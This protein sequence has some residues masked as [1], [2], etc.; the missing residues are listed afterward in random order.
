[1]CVSSNHGVLT[2]IVAILN[3]GN[4]L[5]DSVYYAKKKKKEFIKIQPG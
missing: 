1:M 5:D 4:N 3:L 2:F